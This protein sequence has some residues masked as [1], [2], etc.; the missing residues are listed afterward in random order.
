MYDNAAVG[1]ARMSLDRKVLSINQTAA[2]MTG[3]TMAELVGTDPGRLAYPDDAQIGA[4]EFREM[5]SGKIR[6][7]QV[8][9]RYLTKTGELLWGRVTYSIVPDKDGH[10]ESVVGIIEDVTARRLAD[11]KLAE[12][13]AEYRRTLEQHVEERT[14]ELAE[15]NLKLLDE[16]EQRQRVEDELSAK[17]AEE[18]VVAERTRLARDLHDAVT[19]T[20]FA[21]SLIAEV[22]PDLWKIDA[23]E[24]ARS[25]E[26]L[27]QLTRGALAEMRTLLLELRPAALMQS[28]LGDLIRQLCEALVGRSRL[29]IDL[30]IDGERPLPPE[31]QVAFYRIA[32]RK[33][34]SGCPRP[35]AVCISKS[36]ITASV[37]T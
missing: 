16:I 33:L 24:A 14:H 10:P 13:E 2:R 4:A 37:S 23:E 27:R 36:V 9:K 19:Q 12:Q 18:A 1:M 7:F 34:T 29:P 31:V 35:H 17:A 8:E 6:G 5:V 26:E 20:L 30:K 15:A 32:Q 22:L 11:Q 21:S 25:T 28:K 3:Y